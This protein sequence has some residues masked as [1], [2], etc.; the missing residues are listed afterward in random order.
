M[1]S[2]CPAAT[3]MIP[4]S[5][6][7]PLPG[8]L[9]VIVST[10]GRP[11]RGPGTGRLC[12]AQPWPGITRTIWC[13]HARYALTYFEEVPGMYFTGDGCSRDGVGNHTISGRVDDVINVA[14]HRMGTAEFEFVLAADLQV[15]ECAVV[16]FPHEVKGQSVCAYVVLTNQPPPVNL[17]DRLNALLRDKI[18]AHAKLDVL[19]IV[20]GLP[21]TRSGKC[22][23][24][25]LRSM[26][27]GESD[28]G[29][30]S[31]LADPG[32][33]QAIHDVVCVA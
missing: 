28:F 1:I 13:D 7:L 16:G 22:M 27:K 33:V 15:A 9:P 20:P 6:T 2:G 32:V 5:A 25:I 23:R 24:R 31:T 3:P 30:I 10:Q 29:D 26:A 19:H 17:A 18:G 14:G 8:I 11:I 21:K 12:I 4:G